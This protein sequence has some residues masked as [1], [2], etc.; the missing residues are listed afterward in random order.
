MR[1]QFQFIH[2]CIP[3][4]V[5]L[6][7]V[8]LCGQMSWKSNTYGAVTV[9]S[10]VQLNCGIKIYD[11]SEN[12][13]GSKFDIT[14]C[15]YQINEKEAKEMSLPY[16]AI[17]MVNVLKYPDEFVSADSVDIIKELLTSS[18]PPSISGHA[19]NILYQNFIQ[20]GNDH[21]ISYRLNYNE[22]KMSV[23]TK[24]FFINNSL[25]SIQVYTAKGHTL[26]NCID[27]FIDS[28]HYNYIK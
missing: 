24:A 3:L 27:K 9:N 20:Y 1:V 4:F 16:G 18:I 15:V 13:Q 17:F 14:T 28:F 22:N 23:K 5:A 10:P 11:E 8:M 19:T 21:G 2:L 25:I 12:G 6:S 26:H 7:P